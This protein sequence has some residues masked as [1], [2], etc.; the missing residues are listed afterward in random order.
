MQNLDTSAP[1]QLGFLSFCIN[2][3]PKFKVAFAKQKLQAHLDVIM[4]NKS[5]FDN[6]LKAFEKLYSS[7]NDSN[8][9]YVALK[10]AVYWILQDSER[11]LEWLTGTVAKKE[12][13]TG[14]FKF[15]S[16]LFSSNDSNN[17]NDT[18]EKFNKEYLP[19]LIELENYKYLK[20]FA[21]SLHR[22]FNPEFQTEFS[23]NIDESLITKK[24]NKKGDTVFKC[25]IRNEASY[26][27][28][29]FN[30][31][32]K[33]Y[34][35]SDRIG[36]FFCFFT[37][38]TPFYLSALASVKPNKKDNNF[39]FL[40][41]Q[42]IQE[43]HFFD[44][45]LIWPDFRYSENP[46]EHD[47]FRI[48]WTVELLKNINDNLF[49]SA[50][51]FDKNQP[52]FE[53]FKELASNL[54]LSKS[55]SLRDKQLI[56]ST[57]SNIESTIITNKN[58]EKF[59]TE[60]S[61]N[62][63][64]RLSILLERC[65][66]IKDNLFYSATLSKEDE[67]FFPKLKTEFSHLLEN[68]IISKDANDSVLISNALIALET[69]ISLLNNTERLVDGLENQFNPEKS[70]IY[71]SYFT[72]A[73]NTNHKNLYA[74][75][76]VDRIDWVSDKSDNSS[77]FFKRCQSITLE[78]LIN[79]AFILS[80]SQ[81]LHWNQYK[82]FIY[83]QTFR[84]D[85]IGLRAQILNSFMERNFSYSTFPH[86]KAGKIIREIRNEL[87]DQE[88]TEALTKFELLRLPHLSFSTTQIPQDF[89]LGP[90]KP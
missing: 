9:S 14:S 17:S 46:E 36:S 82:D 10:E 47:N 89:Q 86:D 37:S 21:G 16:M 53:R 6:K 18:V 20:L 40:C 72:S 41:M 44:L 28:I 80:L 65:R 71:H 33:E 60:N 49:K 7:S 51:F 78:K 50:I 88:L 76:M 35:K 59:Y 58:P 54:K 77:D 4:S 90:K 43:K 25:L 1:K 29:S 74:K 79:Q 38:T 81:P 22:S 57:L 30:L 75:W 69:S 67:L 66:G 8:E 27:Y 15:Y 87:K 52:L 23:K 11:L 31:G 45:M 3:D 61:V 83:S 70:S 73:C 26:Y 12:T 85:E 48:K 39:K 56:S 34:L 55:I 13:A 42:F 64:A 5:S 24:F 63:T 19:K 2:N 62:E 84:N 32:L 68:K